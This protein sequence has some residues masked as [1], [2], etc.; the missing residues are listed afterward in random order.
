[1]SNEKLLVDVSLIKEIDG[2][3]KFVVKR[4]LTKEEEQ[5]VA[6]AVEKAMG[7]KVEIVFE[8]E[9]DQE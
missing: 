3:I 4:K 8:I 1:M 6:R 5:K 7:E 9:E 2:K